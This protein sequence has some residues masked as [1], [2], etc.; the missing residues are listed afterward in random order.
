ML[1]FVQIANVLGVHLPL[2]KTIASPMILINVRCIDLILFASMVVKLPLLFSCCLTSGKGGI[3]KSDLAFQLRLEL[4]RIFTHRW[5]ENDGRLSEMICGKHS[6]LYSLMHRFTC[7]KDILDH[8]SK[9][10]KESCDIEA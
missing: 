10:D 7:Q 8:A 1:C 9:K 3:L 6:C 4:S 5:M 2:M